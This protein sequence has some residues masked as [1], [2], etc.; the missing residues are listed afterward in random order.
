[1]SQR[2]PGP[3]FGIVPR[4]SELRRDPLRVVT[5]FHR[6]FGDIVR[7]GD[8]ALT[9]HLLGHPEPADHVLRRHHVNYDRQTRSADAV[10]NVTGESL[11]TND[12]E[13]WRRHR[14]LLQPH[15]NTASVAKLQPVVESAANA[16]I[17]RWLANPT[18]SIDV[19]AEMTR[20]TA[21]IVA[22]AFFGSELEDDADE[23]A[24]LL[25]VILEE[26]YARA[27]SIL[28]LP[29]LIRGWRFREARET[30]LD[31]VER[32][33]AEQRSELLADLSAQLTPDEVRNETL[34]LL[35]AG[36]ETTANAL[37][38]TFLL[39]AQHPVATSALAEGTLAA[40][41]AFEEAMRLYPPIWIVERRAIDDDA[42]AGYAI[43][44]GSIVYVSPYVLHRLPAF[45]RDPDTYDP[46]RFHE[47]PPGER[48]A[49]L[50]FGAG[51]HHCLG[52]HFAMLEGRTIV[53]AVLR[54]CHFELVPGTRVEPQAWITL[55]PR[56]A[57][58]VMVR[59]V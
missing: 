48:E 32:I 10:R 3:G 30:L 50:P 24:R 31:I 47:Q 20:L 39:L 36:H 6:E 12:G 25:P 14:L 19:A 11:L 49:W 2:A 4:L 43:P 9:V 59:R 8:G 45:W 27:T 38:W 23:I 37:T 29:R 46:W 57:V 15:F 42:I 22:R 51:P 26:T 17:D 44:A 56:G 34:A 7:L 18:D 16:M 53:D 41:A 52:G 58:P 55:R 33:V 13:E 54:R 1:V 5:A 28:P 35:L 21:S 40:S